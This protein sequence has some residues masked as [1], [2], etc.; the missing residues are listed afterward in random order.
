MST[1]A[2]DGRPEPSRIVT[3]SA[4]GDGRRRAQR[5]G[6]LVHELLSWDLVRPTDS[7]DFELCEDVQQRLRA[8]A[9]SHPSS[10][11]SVF[12]GRACEACGAT[13][14]LTRMIE[15]VRLCPDCQGAETAPIP[16]PGPEVAALS[17]H[18][19]RGWRRR[20]AG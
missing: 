2:T 10:R 14:Q 12:V 3:V 13:G 5:L 11:P 19:L 1:R 18:G 17:H 4:D 8:A 15:G 20:R 16:F 6:P 7:G 9:R